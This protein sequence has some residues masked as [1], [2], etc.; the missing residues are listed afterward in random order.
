MMQRAGL[1]VS[2]ATV[3]LLAA[4]PAQAAA[5]AGVQADARAIFEKIVSIPTSEGLGKV[6]EMAQ[7]LAD[8][9]RAAGFPDGDIHILPSGETASL[10]VRY[11]GTGRGGKPII[12][13]SHMDVVTARREDWQRDPFQ[14]I[15]EGGYFFG[16]GTEDV[17]GE[18]AVITATFL[19]LR[20]ENFVPARDLI[21]VFTGDEETTAAS[22]RELVTTHRALI[23]AE[24]AL[25]SDGGG[26]RM[27]ERT[28]RP[29]H[30]NLQGAEKSYA[31]FELA[32]RNP[33]GHSSEPRPDNAIYELAD[34][35][36]AL[37]AFAFPVQWN[38]WTI[39]S[40]RAQQQVV[41]GEEGAAMARFAAH[42][43]DPAA[44]AVLARNPALVG[45]IRTTCVPTLLQGGH[46][47]NALPQSATATVNCRVFP[48]TT[49][50]QVRDTLQQVV[51]S[52]VE[53]R[54]LGEPL[55]GPPSPLRE[56][57]LEAVTQVVQA[58][59]PGVP[60][61]PDMAAYA[62]DG[63]MF[64]SAGIPTYGVSSLFLKDSERYAHGLNERIMV[65]TFYDGLDHWYAL[66]RTLAGAK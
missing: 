32:T 23:D 21:L 18:I 64:R 26:G 8:R 5:P 30:Y 50:A 28:G 25:N 12:V 19:R 4:G 24:Y 13:L 52:K 59:F 7:Y 42:P 38:E 34:A 41:Q 29:T 16:R 56:D 17:K 2:V 10:V 39:G 15:E 44:A 49:A 54:T 22:A 1:L 66:L 48:G 3:A 43:G 9:F 37:Q 35:L 63:T 62:T 47:E 46:A 36:R 6:P 11:R 14:L 40:F 53:V 45:R 57:V 58:R 60:V 65:K 27:D 51:G 31:S 20:A 55:V 33:G 61:I